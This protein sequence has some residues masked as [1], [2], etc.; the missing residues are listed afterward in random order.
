SI[1]TAKQFNLSDSEY[2]DFV[3]Y[4]NGKEYDYTTKT[5][6]ALEELK[7]DAKDDKTLD[8]IKA[9]ID[10]LKNKIM[11]N[12]KEDLVKYKPE[13]KQFLEEEIASRYYFQ[14]G[15]LEASLKDDADLKEALGLLNDSD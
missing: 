7:Q 13:I 10:A 5:E 8:A 1:P 12:K 15:R 9:D 6:K 4:L 2:D 11:H 14:N 3:T